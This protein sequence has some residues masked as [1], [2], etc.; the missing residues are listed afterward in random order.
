MFRL[1]IS[2]VPFQP[3]V[4]ISNFNYLSSSLILRIPEY[5]HHPVENVHFHPT[6]VSWEIVE[7]ET[8]LRFRWDENEQFKKDCATDFSG[9]VW[10]D[11]DEVTFQVT[12]QNVG[13]QPHNE[14]VAAFCLQAGAF[15]G[16]HDPQGQMTFIRT[17]DRWVR[18]SEGGHT[19]HN[20]IAKVND[21]EEWV[22]AI[23][24]DQGQNPGGNAGIWPSCLHANPVWRQL[25]PGESE[26]AHG[27]I[28]F[29]RGDLDEAYERFKVDFTNR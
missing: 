18:V 8:H 13:D 23:A 19:E 28:Y 12:M 26:T 7:P 5:I 3:H 20:L 16:Y 24:L 9:E 29:F 17:S 10:A 27:K 1:G 2:Y 14:G 11:R 15:V 25:A 6:N 22:L 21:V 4:V